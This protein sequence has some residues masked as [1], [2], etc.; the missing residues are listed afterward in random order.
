MVEFF[1]YESLSIILHA[2]PTILRQ[3]FDRTLNARESSNTNDSNHSNTGRVRRQTPAILYSPCAHSHGPPRWNRIDIAF[4]FERGSVRRRSH[5]A[6]RKQIYL[7]R[8]WSFGRVRPRSK[9]FDTDRAIGNFP[10][11]P[12]RWYYLSTSHLR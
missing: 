2:F 11:N 3:I 7:W 5:F 1:F 9:K 8:G 10:D 12:E 4:I 6:N